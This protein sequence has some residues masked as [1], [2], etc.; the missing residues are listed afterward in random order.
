MLHEVL[1]EV[2][3]VQGIAFHLLVIVSSDL[4][5]LDWTGFELKSSPSK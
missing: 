2:S 4:F 5:G 3:P 1:H